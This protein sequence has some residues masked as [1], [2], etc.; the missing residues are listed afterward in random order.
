MSRTLW[1]V[2]ALLLAIGG[3]AAYWMLSP[4]TVTVTTPRYGQAV[5][6]VYAT[7]TVE[8]VIMLPVAPRIG[9]RI[10]ALLVDEG[11]VV[12]SGQVLARLESEDVRNNVSQ[13]VA[14][15]D[16][17]HRDFLRDATLVK[18]GVIARQTYDKAKSDW[19]AARAAVSAARAQS[20]YMT[21]TAPTDGR[22]IRRDGEVGQF[23]PVNQ[24]LFWM[25]CLSPLRIAADVDEED[26]ALVKPGQKVLVRA[27]AFPGRIFN[28]HVQEITPK[29]DPIAR[30]YRVRITLDA[31]TPLQIGMT[32][33]TNIITYEK[34]RALLV[35][36][37]AIT[38][39]TVW[40]VRD[41]HVRLQAVV[42]GIAG[43]TDIEITRGVSPSDQIVAKP[44]PSLTD[45]ASVNAVQADVSK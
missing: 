24:P 30:S 7:G 19:D 12:K 31:A 1:I 25:S 16:F 29:G 35:P 8:P 23:L 44:D 42:K 36:A 20:D 39:N 37:S 27:D 38:S 4:P 6:A 26:I 14:Q 18:D 11:A 32:T 10:V 5:Q 43:K 17:A 41:G 34:S 13:L 22:I 21:L 33:E 15:E 28:A 2:G 40:I 3:G 9:A 45:G